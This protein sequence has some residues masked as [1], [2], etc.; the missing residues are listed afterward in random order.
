MPAVHEAVQRI[1]CKHHRAPRRTHYSLLC[2]PKR[3]DEL[4][5]VPHVP[6]GRVPYHAK[7]V[8]EVNA[9][10]LFVDRPQEVERAPNPPVVD[11][12]RSLARAQKFPAFSRCFQFKYK[13]GGKY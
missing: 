4:C 7:H 10:V 3:R 12:S 11:E 6:W 1:I 2:A 9:W 13:F 8:V 5:G